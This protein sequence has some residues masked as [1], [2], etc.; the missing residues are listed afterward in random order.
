VSTLRVHVRR[1]L[2]LAPHPSSSRCF[3]ALPS[4]FS[5][6]ICRFYVCMYLTIF[7]YIFQFC[8]YI[9]I[10]VIYLCV[11]V[12]VCVCVCARACVC[13]CVCVHM[14][15]AHVVFSCIVVRLSFSCFI[16]TRWSRLFLRCVSV[17]RTRNFSFRFCSPSFPIRL[18]PLSTRALFAAASLS[19]SLSLLFHLL[20]PASLSSLSLSLSVSLS[21]PILLSLPYR[22]SEHK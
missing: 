18:P 9:R 1:L 10:Y 21:I 20:C 15:R 5:L 12:C 16:R 14:C 3:S 8:V 13:V 7:M 2:A 17:A 11:C 22:S 4:L 19:L 6:Q